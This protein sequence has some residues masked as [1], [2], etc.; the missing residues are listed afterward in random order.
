MKK[1]I[2]SAKKLGNLNVVAKGTKT[3]NDARP[4]VITARMI[5]KF[6]L[7]GSASELLGVQD[8]DSVI[9]FKLD[10]AEDINEKFFIAKAADGN[11]LSSAGHA[12]GTGR[13]L[14]FSYSSIW[15]L[16]VQM[17]VNAKPLGEQALVEAGILKNVPTQLGRAKE[18]GTKEMCY[19]NLAPFTIGYAL[20][21][22]TDKNEQAIPVEIDG[23]TYEKI[24]VLSDP[25]V[26]KANEKEVYEGESNDEN[27]GK[28]E[29][30]EL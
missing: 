12:K 4:E 17:D 21:L 10:G 19:A 28:I 8:G 25:I 18:D 16:L 27:I 13:P 5:N 6:S 3:T 22:V 2:F 9:M 14:T 7:N 11:K 23:V 24:F 1:S 15:S 29:P 20:S 26:R 30:E